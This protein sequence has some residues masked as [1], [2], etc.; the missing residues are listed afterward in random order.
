MSKVTKIDEY[1]ESKLPHI[2]VDM[3]CIGINQQ[4]VFPVKMLEKYR[5]GE[6]DLDYDLLRAIMS[7]YLDNLKT[8]GKHG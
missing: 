8:R 5:D 3:R 4:R 6:I 2:V 7:E 1:K